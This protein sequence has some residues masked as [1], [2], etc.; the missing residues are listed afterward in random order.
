M[1]VISMSDSNRKHAAAHMSMLTAQFIFSGWHI[2]GSIAL[3]KGADALVFALYREIS[4][5]LL[6]YGLVAY[7]GVRVKIYPP[8]YLRFLFLGFASFVNVV[9]TI[10]A[11]QYISA[12]RYALYQPSIP[13][14]AATISI[15]LGFE[16]F[17]WLKAAGISLAVAGAVLVEAWSSG[18][19][20]ND[21]ETNVNVGTCIVM[22]QCFCMACIVVFQKPLLRKYQPSLVTFVYYSIGSLITILMCICWEFRFHPSMFY[23]DNEMMPWV[24]LAYASVFAT[25]LNYNIISYVG[26]IISPSIITIYATF[27]PIGTMV[28]SPIFLGSVVTL[29]EIVGAVVVICGLLLTVY[30][31][32]RELSDIKTQKY[33]SLRDTEAFDSSWTIDDVRYEGLLKNYIPFSG[34][35]D[36]CFV[37]DDDVYH[38]MKDSDEE[39]SNHQSINSHQESI[40][41]KSPII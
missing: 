27:Q 7:I 39:A 30:A 32:H 6:M 15:I 12:S 20:S 19:T 37:D 28:L 18:S 31:R 34:D 26:K 24:A 9:G 5:S 36:T 13:C 38:Q 2:L 35:Q 10:L 33:Q 25:L 40:V 22:A 23:F 8:D 17:T 29:P 3:R 4:A 16:C 1:K 41:I 14:I 21:D 11:L